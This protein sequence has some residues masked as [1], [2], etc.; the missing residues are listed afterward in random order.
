MSCDFYGIKEVI[1]AYDI[2]ESDYKRLSELLEDYYDDMAMGDYLKDGRSYIVFPAYNFDD[3]YFRFCR[4]GAI[5]CLDMLNKGYGESRSHWI[6]FDLL[7][8]ELK[9][10][11]YE[12]KFID[13]WGTEE[14][15][16]IYPIND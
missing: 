14:T 7:E 12:F 1:D 2:P 3:S 8:K 15:I 6:D 11:F 13:T 16:F 9:D 4:I 5:K 10:E